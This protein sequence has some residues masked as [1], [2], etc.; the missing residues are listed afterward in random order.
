MSPRRL[1]GAT[2][3][4][5]SSRRGWRALPDLHD[6]IVAQH[7]FN[8]ERDRLVDAVPQADALAVLI[9]LRRQLADRLDERIGDPRRRRRAVTGREPDDAAQLRPRA[10]RPQVSRDETEPSWLAEGIHEVRIRA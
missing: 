2:A 1:T 6:Q 3:T 8:P 10:H 7:V 5:A 4:H 9:E